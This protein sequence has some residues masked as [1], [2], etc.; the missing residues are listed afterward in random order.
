MIGTREVALVIALTSVLSLVQGDEEKELL[1]RLLTDYNHLSRP[2]D[3][4]SDI[5]DVYLEFAIIKIADVEEKNKYVKING[6]TKQTWLDKRLSWNPSSHSDIKK[7][8]VPSDLVW[9]PRVFLRNTFDGKVAPPPAPICHLFSNGT[10]ILMSISQFDSHCYLDMQYFPWDRQT[11]Y[12]RFASTMYYS[13]EVRL[14]VQENLTVEEVVQYENFEWKITG[15][16]SE[17]EV[18]KNKVD[19][20]FESLAIY[21]LEMERVPLYYLMNIVFPSSMMFLLSFCV[22]WLPPDCGERLSFAVTLLVA[23]SVFQ[24]LVGDALPTNSN[25]GSLLGVMLLFDMG[26]VASTVVMST[27]LIN[28]QRKGATAKNFPSPWIRRI[29]LSKDCAPWRRHKRNS[30]NKDIELGNV[31]T[32]SRGHENCVVVDM[33][34]KD[35]TGKKELFNAGNGQV[36]TPQMHSDIVEGSTSDASRQGNTSNELSMR[37]EYGNKAT[38]HQEEWDRLV[39]TLDRILFIIYLAV[40]VASLVW[41]LLCPAFERYW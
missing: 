32:C 13:D 20:A 9:I 6:I 15:I 22:F 16:S 23:L 1:N 2:V 11:C 21:R 3:N 5:V 39:K 19:L 28:V 14:N 4:R 12:L 31:T 29:F 25:Y 27:I 36:S 40:S 7:L 10:V 37:P 35:Y 33:D 18:H 30:N 41:L 38:D 8:L 17:V 34:G 24:L 26:M